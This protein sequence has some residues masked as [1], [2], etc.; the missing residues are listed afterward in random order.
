MYSDA[1]YHGDDIS[2]YH[3]ALDSWSDSH[4]L[5]HHWARPGYNVPTAVVAHFFRSPG[6]RIFSALQTALTAWLAFAIA[7]RIAPGR[8]AAAIAPALVWAGPLNMTL[9]IT[10]LTETTAALYLSLSVWLFLRGKS[11]WACLAASPMF[12]T[13]TETMALGPVLLAAAAWEVRRGSGGGLAATLASRR[14]WA[15]A[16]ALLWAPAAYSIAAAAV[17]L[18]WSS[19]LFRIF[20]RS[21]TDEYGRGG[22]LFYVFGWPCAA[23]VG[24]VALMLAGTG[25]T[26][27]RGWIVAAPAYGLFALHTVLYR[28]G[29]FATG[30]YA[31]FLVTAS[32]LVG[33]MG[34]VG[35]GVLVRRSGRWAP[36]AAM[37][38]LGVGAMCFGVWPYAWP[39]WVVGGVTGAL[40]GG[41]IL[42]WRLGA[43]PARRA[44]GGIVAACA[45][46]AVLWQAGA[47]IRPLRG[48]AYHRAAKQAYDDL[49]A[50]GLGDGRL[51]STYTRASLWQRRRPEFFVYG[52]EG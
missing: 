51:L 40:G 23:G 31:R 32:G 47:E 50:A 38:A 5:L 48:D 4:R 13:R 33:A 10:T 44:V 3:M 26:I 18:P 39:V 16:A 36:A 49:Q 1:T 2:H 20:G 46:G 45:M 7:R 22:W 30:G 19:H 42:A 12:L 43:G 8:W 52:D 29:M 21:Y 27:R 25:R 37:G 35:V 28:Y 34:A 14:L 41:M 17:Q 15:C 6:C 24:A 11:V 9:A